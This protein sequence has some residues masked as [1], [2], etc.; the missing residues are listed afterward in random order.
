[1]ETQPQNTLK[2][3]RTRPEILFALLGLLTAGALAFQSIHAWPA[4]LVALAVSIYLLAVFVTRPRGPARLLTH[5][6]FTVCFYCAS[7]WLTDELRS[8][9]QS[10]LLLT[11]D[12]RL[13]GETPSV[14]LEQISSP[15]L[16]DVMSL[17]YFTYLVYLNWTM[18]HALFQSGHFRFCLEGV[19]PAFALGFAG[20]LLLPG[21]SPGRAFPELYTTPLH[22]GAL[23]QVNDWIVAHA[24]AD[25]DVFP[26][27]H[28]LVTLTL[29][30]FDWHNYRRRFWIMI[31]PAALLMCSTLYL[32][33]HYAV[34]LLAAL[35]LLG[36]PACEIRRRHR[37]AT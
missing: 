13:L 35:L 10:R 12:R 20:Y 27:L 11:W 19:F 21:Q 32:R 17:F 33:F 2:Q 16:T 37:H 4:C 7:S 18:F 14:W 24:G 30:V 3:W 28:I 22:G 15:A 34:D 8:P 6:T 5:Y 25:Y 23:T 9:I 29:L 26:S 36:F 1:M 31:G